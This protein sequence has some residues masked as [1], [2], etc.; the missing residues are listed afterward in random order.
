MRLIRWKKR[1]EHHHRLDPH[2][3]PHNYHLES[4]S[5]LSSS[6]FSSWSSSSGLMIVNVVYKWASK[7][8][9]KGSGSSR[10]SRLSKSFIILIKLIIVNCQLSIS[11]L[12]ILIIFIHE[13]DEDDQERSFYGWVNPVF[14]VCLLVNCVFFIGQSESGMRKSF[15]ENFLSCCCCWSRL[16]G[17]HEDESTI[18]FCLT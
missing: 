16:K 11:T 2:P 18:K 1:L 12:E 3:P 15:W 5:S 8:C 9:K 13:Y 7:D 14:F 17:G 6:S 4:W 10:T